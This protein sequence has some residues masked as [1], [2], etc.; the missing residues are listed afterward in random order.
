MRIRWISRVVLGA[1]ALGATRLYAAPLPGL[2][3]QKVMSKLKQEATAQKLAAQTAVRRHAEMLGYSTDAIE[4][5]LKP[6]MERK[7]SFTTTLKDGTV[8]EFPWYRTGF[9]ENQIA[10]T[11]KPIARNAA[12]VATL[13]ETNKGGV[14]LHHGVFPDEVYALALKMDSK[15]ATARD[16]L[17]GDSFRGAKGGIGA[18]RVIK[19]GTE[20][21]AKVGDLVDPASA[22]VDRADVMRKFGA[23]Y[24]ASGG[25]VG[26]GFDIQAGDVNTKA[27]EMKVLAETYGTA[28]LPSA[29]V[30]GKALMRLPNGA[31][32][33]NGG[34][35][36]RARSTGEGVWDAARLAAKRAGTKLRGAT[37]VAQGWGEVGRAFGE[38]ALRDGVKI[39]AIEEMWKVGDKMVPGVLMNPNG[40]GTTPKQTAAW[41]ASV[42]IARASGEDLLTTQ[43]GRFAGS[44]K[45]GVGA[46]TLRA[47]IVGVNALGDVLNK[48]TVPAYVESGTHQGH[49]KIIV[50]GAN[51]AETT[52]GAR[53]LDLHREHL[54]TVPGDLANLGGVHVSN[55]EAAQNLFHEA[56]SDARAQ[57]SVRHAISAAWT[58]SMKLATKYN[59]SER[60]AIELSATDGL[61]KRS[62]QLK[63]APK[64]SV[65][66]LVISPE[67]VSRAAQRD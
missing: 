21:E 15:L 45:R 51:L 35:E 64:A 46:A 10:N 1:L 9:A 55:L 36:F 48:D 6:T 24:R 26:P 11:D 47:D 59:L 13:H 61:M 53:L 18:G 12:G 30:S 38:A 49:R 25:D 56:V 43:G 20:Y 62:L 42:N 19:V 28:A 44:F 41:L 3:D 33:P 27:P 29:G 34:I 22:V 66:E 23:S 17:R 32:D 16:A 4:R 7:G 5:A 37:V 50:E 39:V 52:E 67:A 65:E 40:E 60:S 31:I 14:R 2:L 63:G 8:I 57:K 54:L 58:R